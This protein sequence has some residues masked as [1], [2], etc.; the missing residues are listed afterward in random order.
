MSADT[1]ELAA[2]LGDTTVAETVLQ[3]CLDVAAGMLTP[4]VPSYHRGEVGYLEAV[5]LLAV[6]VFEE[7]ARGRVG[8]DP[9]GEFDTAYLPGPTRGM[10]DSVAAYWGPLAD[11]A[12]QLG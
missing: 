3:R 4:L 12:G 2:R 10:V 11:V 5:Q 9:A 8:V 7:R 6:R 1:D